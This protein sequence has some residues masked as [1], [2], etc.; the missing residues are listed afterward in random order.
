MTPTNDLTSNN[1]TEHIPSSTE[2]IPR[3]PGPPDGELTDEQRAIQASI[4]A[5]RPGTGLRGSF[6]PW[7]SVP[8]I[9]G[10]AQA[11]GRACRYE[12][13]L[14]YRESELIILLTAA[15]TRSHTEFDIHVGEAVKAGIDLNVIQ[16]IPR[17]GDF[18]VDAVNTQLI[19]SLESGREKSICRFA[20]ELLET[21]TVSDGTY[22]ET[23]RAV[24]GKD[25]VLV[26]I[27]SICGYYTYVAYTLNVFR[28]PS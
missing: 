5:S 25:S 13:S 28:I 3:H 7:L 14:S 8:N 20:A 16:L 23:K 2:Y 19:P 10:P 4:L 18:S 12:T 27:T 1:S 15:K 22:D 6:G 26:E 21:F 24:E 11:L 9:A 17:D